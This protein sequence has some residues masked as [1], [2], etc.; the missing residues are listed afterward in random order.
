VSNALYFKTGNGTAPYTGAIKTIG[1]ST[2]AARL[3]L[4]TY[5]ASSPNLLLERLS[6][7]DD[8]NVGIGTTTPHSKL[9]ITQPATATTDVLSITQNNPSSDGRGIVV[10][11]WGPG[12]GIYSNT[13]D[14]TAI[15]ANS[16]SIS[17]AGV[18]AYNVY[19][20]ASVG[21]CRGGVGVGAVVGRN[22]STGYGVRGF[23][24]KNGYGVVGEG[25]VNS[26]NSIAGSFINV[27]AGNPNNVLEATGNGTGA[28]LSV[29]N[30]NANPV[31]SL[32]LFKKGNA[33]VA[34]IDGTGKGF[35][36]G[37]TQSSG[38]DLAEAFDVADDIKNYEP[39]DVLMISID[40]DRS[41]IKSSVAYS[42]LVIGVYATRP[43]VLLTE[44]NLDANLN[45]KIPM[46][47]VGVIPTKVCLQGGEIKRG[48]ML[49]TS[50][51]PGVAMK[52]DKAKI[53]TGK[54]LGKA[55]ENFNEDGIGKIKVFINVR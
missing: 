18:M 32:A 42:E 49:V 31:S 25:G 20:E 22:D 8:G 28:T 12:I 1:I 40:K 33:N 41:V 38:A 9:E 30:T 52:A 16:A 27:N 48:D 11:N 2:N 36:N 21:I 6:I 54:C 19:G 17:G 53:Q 4:F 15:F 5:A 26:G 14:G 55:L 13:Y 47:V 23:N 50:G 46:G 39:G 44:E 37:G 24:T 45:D 51:I 34:R 29:Q 7:T 3:G 43:G 35:F 10:Q